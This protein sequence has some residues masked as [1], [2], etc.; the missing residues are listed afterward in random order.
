MAHLR[1]LKRQQLCLVNTTQNP[2]IFSHRFLLGKELV[3]KTISPELKTVLDFVV[4]II[5]YMKMRPLKRRQFAKQY[6]SM[7]ANHVMFNSIQ[8]Y[9]G[10]HEENSCIVSVHYENMQS[11]IEDILKSTDKINAFRRN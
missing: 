7:I 8:I 5:N 2:N 3:T 6:E 9:D 1:I 4:N 10:C 11:K